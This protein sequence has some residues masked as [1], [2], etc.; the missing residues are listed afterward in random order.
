MRRYPDN[1]ETCVREARL[2]M[3]SKKKKKF[4]GL[5]ESKKKI[6]SGSKLKK[7]GKKGLQTKTKMEDHETNM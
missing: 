7:L 4:A 6:G 3:A 2:A 5:K 1:L